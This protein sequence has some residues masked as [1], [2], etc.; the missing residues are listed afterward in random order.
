MA[1]KWHPDLEDVYSYWE[2]WGDIPACYVSFAGGYLSVCFFAWLIA[3]LFDW[4]IVCLFVC[5]VACFHACL[6]VYLVACLL[7]T[8][9]VQCVC[10]CVFLHVK[11]GISWVPQSSISWSL[12]VWLTSSSCPKHNKQR[13]W[14]VDNFFAGKNSFVRR[15]K[16]Q[17]LQKNYK[18][19]S[20]QNGYWKKLIFESP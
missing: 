16:P 15:C 2:K 1:G 3:C 13:Y 9:K 12:E 10:V 5:L 6:F 11:F 19:R 7:A 20:P 8:L 4:L 14:M 18:E 17:P